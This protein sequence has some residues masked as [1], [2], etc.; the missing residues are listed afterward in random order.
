MRHYR[1]VGQ[2]TIPVG[3]KSQIIVF[4]TLYRAAGSLK[5]WQALTALMAWLAEGMMSGV[6]SGWPI[7]GCPKSLPS[8]PR[9]HRSV[10]TTGRPVLGSLQCLRRHDVIMLL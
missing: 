4:H 7:R 6:G 5:G 8:S 2:L 3:S 10:T 1:D 9:S